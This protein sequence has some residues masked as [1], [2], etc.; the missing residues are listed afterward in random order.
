MVVSA[1]VTA[2]GDFTT[3]LKIFNET[4]KLEMKKLH[5]LDKKET[6]LNFINQIMPDSNINPNDEGQNKAR[7]KARNKAMVT[8]RK[9]LLIWGSAESIIAM[10]EFE[11]FGHNNPKAGNKI[12]IPYEKLIRAIRKDL[13]HD[14]TDLPKSDL[15]SIYL[16]ADGKEE[17]KELFD[18]E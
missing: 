17:I 11:K 15:A 12:F 18:A 6:Y 2:F 10:A 9:E 8:F 5:F 7:A 4:K 16:D 13:G 1:L 3:Q 14:D